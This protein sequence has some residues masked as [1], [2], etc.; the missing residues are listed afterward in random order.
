MQKKTPHYIRQ[1]CKRVRKGRS[2]L[3]GKRISNDFVLWSDIVFENETTYS[4]YALTIPLHIY[5]MELL[6]F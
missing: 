5:I 3:R 6:L 1:L 4:L 2:K